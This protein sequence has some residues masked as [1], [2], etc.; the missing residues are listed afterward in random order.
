[1]LSVSTVPTHESTYGDAG[2]YYAASML[3]SSTTKE[4]SKCLLTCQCDID[5]ILRRSRC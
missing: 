3:V 1:M 2:G 4:G 5:Q